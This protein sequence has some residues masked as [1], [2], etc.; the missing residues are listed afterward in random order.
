MTQLFDE[1][2]FKSRA[3]KVINDFDFNTQFDRDFAI[4]NYLHGDVS[5]FLQRLELIN[6]VNL[7]TFLD[8]G[9]GYGQWA[10]AASKVNASVVAIDPDPSRIEFCKR[11][12]E[13]LGIDNI[14][15]SVGNSEDLVGSKTFDAVFLFGVL[16]LV[17]WRVELDKVVKLLNKDGKLYFNA[18]DYGYIMFNLIENPNVSDTFGGRDWAIE[19]LKNTEQFNAHGVFE[20]SNTREGLV[21]PKSDMKLYLENLPGKV[22]GVAGDGVL[23]FS[24]KNQSLPFFPEKYFGADCVYEVVYSH[25]KK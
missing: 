24:G 19:C 2:E 13:E 21:I 17:S 22:L 18:N 8:I 12:S 1:S 14:E 4:R 23:D 10:I 25:S 15:F 3:E 20:P 16:S 7:P 5:R 11:L 6:F 9:C